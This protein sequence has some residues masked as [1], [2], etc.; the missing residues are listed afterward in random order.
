MEDTETVSETPIPS[1]GASLNAPSPSLPPLGPPV[2]KPSFAPPMELDT[3]TTADS[4]STTGERLQDDNQDRH[5]GRLGEKRKEGTPYAKRGGHQNTKQGRKEKKK[6]KK[7]LGRTAFRLVELDFEP[8]CPC[9]IAITVPLV[10]IL[11]CD[12]FPTLFLYHCTDIAIDLQSRNLENREPGRSA[13][14]TTKR[15]K[16]DGEANDEADEHLQGEKEARRPKRKVAVLIGY[17]GHGYKGMQLN[18][19]NKT[20]EG[21]LFEAFV[22][23]GAISR[24]NSNDPKKSSLVRCA[25]T[26]KGVHAAGN[27]ISLKLIIEDSD[28]VEK[29]NSHLPD[30]IRVWG[31]QRTLSSFNCYQLCDSRVYEYLIPSYVFLPPHPNTYLGKI[32]RKHAIEEN[33]LEGW[34][35]RQVEVST[36]W[37]EVQVEVDKLLE[38]GGHTRADF[39]AAT[40]SLFEDELSQHVS[41]S[42][43]AVAINTLL[44]T[45][46]ETTPLTDSTPAPLSTTTRKLPDDLLKQIKHLHLIR[47]RLFRLPLTRLTR[48]RSILS[49]YC[50]SN[51]FHNYTIQKASRD[52]SAMRHIKTFVA[53]DPILING[54]EYLSLR[55]HGQSFMMHQIRKMVG[56]ALLV[57]RCGTDANLIPQ[58]YTDVAIAIPKAPGVGLLLDHPVF[59]SYNTKCVNFPDRDPIGFTK[60]QKEIDAFREKFIYGRMFAEEE[61]AGLFHAFVTFI[62]GYRSEAFLYL[63]SKGLKAVEGLAKG[64]Q[65]KEVKVKLVGMEGEDVGEDEEEEEELDMAGGEG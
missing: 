17:S 57:V 29:I 15:I 47:K 13:E 63:G 65:R 48:L 59:D 36:F 64:G 54:V 38:A 42:P 11:A 56:L 8:R 14:P 4:T 50:G 26:D 40:D 28:I 3:T 33:D 43:A 52:P 20:I 1:S 46:S 18:Y 37:D 5:S 12:P 19:P 45:N 30:Q 32:L 58:T 35:S 44:S 27:V 41:D 51:N 55:V 21:D 49:S 31:I 16:L 10:Y 23:A 6:G 61:K 53:Q 34:E 7:E 39:D 25:R 60:Y 62:D 22:R 9:L 2:G 24:A